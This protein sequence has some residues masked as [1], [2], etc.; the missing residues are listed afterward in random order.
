MSSNVLIFRL[1]SNE[2]IAAQS[3][4]NSK[5]RTY[6]LVWPVE[7][8]FKRLSTGGSMIGLYPWL[9]TEIIQMNSSVIEESKVMTIN[10]PTE[11]F[12]EY[13]NAMVRYYEKH[14][15]K[16]LADKQLDIIIKSYDE[17][18]ISESDFVDNTFIEEEEEERLIK[19][20]SKKDKKLH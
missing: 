3:R 18:T 19:P 20:K 12:I 15:T 8:Y 5:D 13:Y 2:I 6:H 10:H 17:D 9:V 11:K 16:E 14:N 7:I 1:V 4:Y